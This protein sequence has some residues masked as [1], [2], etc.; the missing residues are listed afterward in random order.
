MHAADNTVAG[1]NRVRQAVDIFSFTFHLFF[2]KKGCK[3]DGNQKMDGAVGME[4]T[5]DIFG[6]EEP[7]VHHDPQLLVRIERGHFR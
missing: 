2:G 5:V 4:E 3:R 6:A 1:E 7:F